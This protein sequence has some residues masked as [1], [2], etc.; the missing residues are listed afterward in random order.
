MIL[1]GK[2][3]ITRHRIPP[4]SWF[5]GF[6]FFISRKQGI[7]IQGCSNNIAHKHSQLTSTNSRKH[8][9]ASQ[10]FV[11]RVYMVF[12][13]TMK[14][15]PLSRISGMTV[16]RRS[17]RRRLLAVGIWRMARIV[18]WPLLMLRRTAV[19]WVVSMLRWRV[20]LRRAV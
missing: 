11:F 17:A 1:Q 10:P 5:L 2:E 3:S 6:V 14:R 8:P 9:L 18:V 7:V 4:P 16:G 19:S 20:L 12:F 15:L 13:Q